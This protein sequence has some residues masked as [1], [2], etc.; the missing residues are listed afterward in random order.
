MKIHFILHDF[1][2]TF[3]TRT[4]GVEG[5]GIRAPMESDGGSKDA[6]ES[7]VA[8][9]AIAKSGGARDA[10]EQSEAAKKCGASQRLHGSPSRLALGSVI[11]RVMMVARFYALL[12]AIFRTARARSL[13]SLARFHDRS[14]VDVDGAPRLTP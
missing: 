7:A 4:L 13:L 1:W 11:G 9:M 14:K 6:Q 5:G 2:A 8:P 12:T 3:S 10:T